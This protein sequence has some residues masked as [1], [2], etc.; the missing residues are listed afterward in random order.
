MT[1]ISVIWTEAYWEV[2][3]DKVIFHV[4]ANRFLRNMVRAIV[5]TLLQ[6]GMGKED[7]V[8]YE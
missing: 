6:I 8:V 2:G 5:G 4:T 7:R 3:A 1:I